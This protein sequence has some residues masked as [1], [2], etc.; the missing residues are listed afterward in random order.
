MGNLRTIK[1][2][3]IKHV[4]SD[5]SNLVEGD[6]WY[7][8]STQTLKIAPKLS[9]TW[10][11]GEN[12]PAAIRDNGGFGITTAAAMFGGYNA[13]TDSSIN[14]TYEY[15]GTD[16]AS[17]GNLPNTRSQLKGFG[18]Q[19]AG[20]C[21]GHSSGGALTEEYNGSTW[22]EGGDLNNGRASGAACG[23]LTAGLYMG[24]AL[25]PGF[26]TAIEEYDGSSWA[27][28]PNS[29]STG[30]TQVAGAGVQTAAFGAGGYGPGTTV[31]AIT[32]EYDGSAVSSG[33]NLNTARKQMGGAG[34]LTAGIIMGGSL[35]PATGATEEYDGTAW[36]SQG[37]MGTGR[38]AY[39]ASS[40]Q[41][42]TAVVMAGYTGPANQNGTEE[43]TAG[44]V[45]ARTADTS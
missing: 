3:Y 23:T 25:A 12:T 29:L 30:R 31:Q 44:V 7:N 37:N 11:A 6:I 27:S 16:Y 4:S 2:L 19:T 8:T 18:T 5:P 15:D 35:A 28:N 32:E 22:A 34:T 20:V 38:Y 26:A 10:A 21:V 14:E 33:G 42:A 45:G 43:Y 1:G 17:G 9:G 40:Q 24:G 36:A 41:A 39:A 13:S